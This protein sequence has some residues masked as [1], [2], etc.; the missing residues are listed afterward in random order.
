MTRLAD[1][2]IDARDETRFPAGATARPEAADV[3]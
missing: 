2:S 3:G 1:V